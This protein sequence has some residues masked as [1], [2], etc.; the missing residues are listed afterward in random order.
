MTDIVAETPVME[1]PQTHQ[2]N[3]TEP[4]VPDYWLSMAADLREIA[5][6]IATLAGTPMPHGFLPPSLSVAYA[7]NEAD[8]EK[9]VPVVDAI[10]AALGSTAETRTDGRG[11]SRRR[12]RV[13]TVRVGRVDV[14]AKA[15]MP[16]PPTR[17]QTRAELEDRVAELEAQLA[18]SGGAR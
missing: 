5:N 14:R 10:A 3:A 1:Q 8:A 4:A 17:A 16:V 7:Y 18:Q 12:S 15:D 6:R 13:M 9:T 11:R 2:K